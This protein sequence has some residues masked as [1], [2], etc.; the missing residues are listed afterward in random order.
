MSITVYSKPSC[1]RCDATTRL[2]DRLE[3]NYQVI[4]LNTDPAA[5]EFVVSLGY[6]EAPV[7][8]TDIGHWSGYRIEQI[9]AAVA[10]NQ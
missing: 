2:L 7:V 6:K 5:Y 8:I 4:D 9:R 1:P 3:A 10:A